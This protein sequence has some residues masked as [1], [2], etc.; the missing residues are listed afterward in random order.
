MVFAIYLMELTAIL[1]VFRV[2][3]IMFLLSV[4]FDVLKENMKVEKYVKQRS[5]LEFENIFPFEG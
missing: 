5:I 4:V 1:L 2:S 3:C